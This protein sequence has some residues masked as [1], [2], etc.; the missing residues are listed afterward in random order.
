MNSA[1]KLVKQLA[2]IVEENNI[3]PLT[4]TYDDDGDIKYDCIPMLIT[5][6]ASPKDY[7]ITCDKS[8]VECSTCPLAMKQGTWQETLNEMKLEELLDE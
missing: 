1:N 4:G 6:M 7:V 2:R 8:G 3:V 5:Q